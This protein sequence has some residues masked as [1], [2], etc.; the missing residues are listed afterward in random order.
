M[1][2][3]LIAKGF[4]EEEI[5]TESFKNDKTKYDLWLS[6]V[7]MS[8]FFEGKNIGYGV[9]DVEWWNERNTA[10]FRRKY[11]KEEAEIMQKELI[12]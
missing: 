5:A 8:M 11:S 1:R 12:S 9:H 4:T 6:K 2:D 7:P 10:N 3:W